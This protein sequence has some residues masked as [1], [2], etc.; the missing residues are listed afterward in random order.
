[1]APTKVNAVLSTPEKQS[2]GWACYSP[3]TMPERKCKRALT[4]IGLKEKS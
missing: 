3:Q 2:S 4:A 1:M